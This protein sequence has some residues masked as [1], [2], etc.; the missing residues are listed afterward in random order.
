MNRKPF[1]DFPTA[2]WLPFASQGRTKHFP[3]GHLIYL[4][5]TNATCFYYLKSGKVK[6]FIQSEDGNERVL[7]IYT[8]GSIF[9]EAAFF[10]ELPRISSAITQSSCEVVSIDK[11]TVEKHFTQSPELALSM[12]NYLARTV[13]LLSNQVD[14]MAFRPA[15]QRVARYLMNHTDCKGKVLTTQEDIANS[16][17]TSRVTVSRILGKFAEKGLLTTSYG[18]IILNDLD[19]LEILCEG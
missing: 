2:L 19:G 16:I 1:D 8:E 14:D 7:N 11:K 12:I 18:E 6:S 15:S 5:D 9:G 13:R 17:S 10:D 3:E 4:Q